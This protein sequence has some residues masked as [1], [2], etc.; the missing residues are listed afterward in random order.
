MDC[1][2]GDATL[3]PEGSRKQLKQPTHE[4]R[5]E[6]RIPRHLANPSALVWR[7]GSGN[8]DRIRGEGPSR[9]WRAAAAL[10]RFR[11]FLNPDWIVPSASVRTAAP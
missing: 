1:S 2:G 6:R 11:S 4:G 10:T 7:P 9:W 8:S 5:G 3:A